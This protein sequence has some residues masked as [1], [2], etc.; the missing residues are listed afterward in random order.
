[1][2][3]R[4]TYSDGDR[5]LMTCGTCRMGS[6]VDLHGGT[7]RVRCFGGCDEEAALAG[8]D[9]SRV[10]AELKAMCGAE[11]EARRN[12]ATDE[13]ASG[14]TARRADLLR[15]RPVEWLWHRRI[16]V[17][18]L[19]LLLG[20][21]GMGKGVLVAWLIARL[22]RGE[23]PGDREGRPSR[24]LI[25]GEED[26]FESVIV[27]R[28]YA[29]GA[30]LDLVDE[31]VADEETDTLDV[32]RDGER[33][34]AL[35]GEHGYSLVYVDQLLDVLTADTDDWR[36][37]QVRDALRP[38]RR[39]ARELH[40]TVLGTL[41][42]N[43]G[44]RGNFRDLVSGSHAFNAV[45]R[46]SLLLAQHHDDAARRVLVR[47]KGNLSAAPPSFEFTLQGR[48]LEIND[49]AFDLPVLAHEEEGE[50]SI[51][52]LLKPERPAPVR[53]SLA[54]QI[55]ALGTGEIQSRAELARAVGRKPDDRHVGRAL[56]QLE[57]DG[58][59]VK[60]ARGKWRRIGIG[61]SSATPISKTDGDG[62][63]GSGR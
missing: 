32:G 20:A 48:E 18:Y 31:L 55:D 23:L 19:S 43:K 44:Q 60:K 35:I 10:L 42:P 1:M 45:A 59:W 16:P 27:P 40:T 56:D 15:V 50:Q 21:E 28:L 63:A 34:R 46:S 54:D 36:S 6:R 53:E 57:Q 26:S 52:D 14:L 3:G 24:V 61:A 38:L 41:H 11:R 9:R 29:A 49:Y 12:G 8:Y 4:L 47:G 17:G 33:L 22:T 58:R 5:T 13:T 51:E 62:F 37:K 30:D 7:L 2:T 39:A 25:V